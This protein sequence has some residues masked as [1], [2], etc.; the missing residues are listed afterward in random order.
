MRQAR[1]EPQPSAT[2]SLR[3]TRIGTREVWLAEHTGFVSCPVYARDRLG[4]GHRIEGPAVIEQMDATT[5]VLPGQ[6][7]SVDAYLNML[8]AD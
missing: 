6:A 5:L 2:N 4:P 3:D 8:I 7:A 1:I